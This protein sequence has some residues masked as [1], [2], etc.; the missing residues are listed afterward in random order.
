MYLKFY[1]F[2]FQD[3][4]LKIYKYTWRGQDFWFYCTSKAQTG[5][6]PIQDPKFQRCVTQ[7]LLEGL[8][9][10]HLSS[11]PRTELVLECFPNVKAQVWCNGLPLWWGESRGKH[12]LPAWGQGMC[13]RPQP[14][15]AGHSLGGVAIHLSPLHFQMEPHTWRPKWEQGWQGAKSIP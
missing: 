12:C 6:E 8:Q 15:P 5:E 3:L 14:T 9:S 10:K 4:K 11:I 1:T 2:K 7:K 13:R